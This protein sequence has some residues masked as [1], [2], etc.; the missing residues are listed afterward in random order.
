M[1][2]KEGGKLTVERTI[3]GIP[4]T[5]EELEKLNISNETLDDIVATVL[6]R[7]KDKVA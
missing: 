4:I 1:H 7:R 5:K 6:S 3:N 2:G